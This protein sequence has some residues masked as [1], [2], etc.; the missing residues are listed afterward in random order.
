MVVFAW[1]I[2]NVAVNERSILRLDLRPLDYLG[3]ISYGIYMYHALAISL[4][5]VP[6]REKYQTAPFLPATLLLHL[7]VAAL[8]LLL[9]ATSK[10]FFENKFLRYKRRFQPPTDR[11][12]TVG[13]CN[14]PTAIATGDLAA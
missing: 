3:D 11:S 14:H 6:L 7:L 8:T 2:L 4:L 13:R 12:E 5:F 9:A 10:A 1:F